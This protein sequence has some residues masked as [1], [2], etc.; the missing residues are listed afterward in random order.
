[1]QIKHEKRGLPTYG[2]EAGEAEIVSARELRES[3]P[4][5]RGNKFRISRSATAK[6][7]ETTEIKPTNTYDP[8]NAAGLPPDLPVATTLN[9]ANAG[10]MAGVSASADDAVQLY[11]KFRLT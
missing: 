8:T 5:T 2:C 11:R 4:V 7:S 3:E 9:A 1:M 6:T 10:L